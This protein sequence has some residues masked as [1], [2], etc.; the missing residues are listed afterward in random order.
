M[1]TAKKR[2]K[3]PA[4][5]IPVIVVGTGHHFQRNVAPALHMLEEAGHIRMLATVDIVERSA[6]RFFTGGTYIKRSR[7][8]L[9]AELAPYKKENPLVILGHTNSLHAKDALDLLSHGFRVAIDKPYALDQ[10]SLSKIFSA[11]S[12]DQCALI[13]YYLTMKS[14]PLLLGY[15]KLLPKSFYLTESLMKPLP[16]LARLGG[17]VRKLHGVLPDRIG[18]VVRVEVEVLEGEGE[19]GT[20]EGRGIDTIDIRSGGGMIEDMA[21]HA[22]APVVALADQIGSLPPRFTIKIARAEEYLKTVKRR[23]GIPEKY[24][25]ETYAEYAGQSDTGVDIVVRFGKYVFGNRNR[26]GIRLVGT[27]GS[28][29]MDWN[30]CTLEVDGVPL[31]E[32]HK[33]YYPVLRSALAQVS[34]DPCYTFDAAAVAAQAQSYTFDVQRRAYQGTGDTLY[35]TGAAPEDIFI[36]GSPAPHEEPAEEAMRPQDAHDVWLQILEKDLP[37]FFPARTRTRSSCPGCGSLDTESPFKKY[38]FAYAW[39]KNC[40][41]LYASP[42]PSEKEINAFYA[43][44]KAMRFYGESLF[45][46]SLA[47]R[48][49]QQIAPIAAWVRNM[50]KAHAPRAAR[51]LD[52]MPKYFTVWA[53]DM[54][55][56]N[57]AKK[58]IVL[59]DP[60]Y[61]VRIP[62]GARVTNFK[63]AQ[64]GTYDVITAFDVLDHRADP[65]GTVKELAGL[66]SPRGLLL[67]AVNVGSGFEYQVLGEHSHRLVPPNRLNLLSAE[68]I[69]G[70]LEE[71]GLEI[72]D[73]ST[74]GRLDVDIVLKA[75]SGRPSMPTSRFISYL[76]NK[77]EADTWESLQDFLGENRLSSYLRIA[78]RKK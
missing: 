2:R 40:F 20:I 71:N 38:G 41:S 27:K 28:V 25:G 60:V 9:S 58:R 21:M 30:S 3:A 23:F 67:I 73:E 76:L 26:R 8:A 14:A 46:P 53:E 7:K 17:S 10:D 44:S 34:G 69:E 62:K 13:E 66:L 45:K 22:F 33:N 11:A 6:R 51:V 19:T 24:I 29:Y 50:V 49:E 4:K 5:P 56:K 55:K 12:E 16:G 35:Q 77:R 59:A 18:R 78:A 47:A 36:E 37:K 31:L 39:C 68:A 65:S 72:V 61:P 75:L 43:K 42:R 52:F 64:K 1:A 15:G 54:G 70:L 32:M 57:H 63:S 74:P 48:E